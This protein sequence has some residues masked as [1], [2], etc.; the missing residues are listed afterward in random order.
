M[1]PHTSH[2]EGGWQPIPGIKINVGGGKGHPRLPGWSIVDLREGADVRMDITR[3]RLPFADRSVETI[4]TSHTLEHIPPQS[5]GFVLSEF[6]RVLRPEGLLRIGVPDIEL[7]TRAYVNNDRGFFERSEVTPMDRG[8]P[9]GG[10]LMSWF[11][12]TSAVGSGHVHCFDE[13]YLRHWLAKHG[14]TGIVRSAFRQSQ[15]EELR[16]EAFDRHPNDT[17]FMEAR[18]AGAVIAAA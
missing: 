4:F 15:D 7:A 1:K 17:L 3:D 18:R 2:G 16:S 12:S 10:L 8:A 13:A 6:A 14:F 11:Y 5:L 9:L